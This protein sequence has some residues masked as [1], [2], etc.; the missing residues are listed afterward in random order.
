M[1]DDSHEDRLVEARKLQEIQ[2]TQDTHK[3]SESK[4]WVVAAKDS[5][6]K[7]TLSGRIEPVALSEH[8]FEQARRNF[9]S[10][11]TSTSLPKRRRK[12]VPA[13]DPAAIDGYQG[14]WAAPE[15]SVMAPSEEEISQ[16]VHDKARIIPATL[17]KIIALGQ[18]RSI[19]HGRSERDHLGQTYMSPPVGLGEVVE[20][21]VCHVP[22]KLLHTFT[23]HTKGVNCIRFLPR[24]G[25]LLLSA[26]QDQ[27][28]KLWDVNSSRECLR[29][30]Y[31]HN[32]PVR[33]V[34]FDADGT[35][36]AS[37]SYDKTF[38]VWSTETGQC[39]FARD[40]RAIPFC[41]S[42]HPEDS[43]TLLVGT[44]DRRIL[45]WD[46]RSG[47]KVMEY[48]Q[49]NGA[50]NSI[51]FFNGNRNFV[52]SSDDRTLRVW[53]L[54]QATA[55]KRI[56]GVDMTNMPC[57]AVHPKE[58]F[59]VF[60]SLTNQLVTYA[61]QDYL[62]HRERPLG[63]HNTGGYPCQVGFSPDGK[64][65]YSGDGRGQVVVWHWASG[66]IAKRI[67]AHPQVCIDVQW[68]PMR[69]S[70]LATCSWDGTIKYWE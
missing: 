61:Q 57:A 13:G 70:G 11:T 25:H 30:F 36:F 9:V 4:V 56:G 68:H 63:G 35:H 7:E 21:S 43:N 52:T 66:K 42:L 8:D 39:V 58:P 32:K 17:N 53:E 64:F 48:A 40:Y 23:D 19:F 24:S 59:V 26:A 65:V 41:V 14:S 37:C 16:Y 28:I 55:V 46:L 60:Q 15:V 50:V 33:Q 1:E 29:T 54:L 20:A 22:R 6:V 5:L 38:K 18:E 3:A 45:Q 51:T 31:G 44:A 47:D 69:P 67:D 49:H 34:N 12:A 27:R 10:S 2:E 62:V